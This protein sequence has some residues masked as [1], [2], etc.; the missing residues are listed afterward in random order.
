M[1]DPARD[2]GAKNK[3]EKTKP[4]FELS[5]LDA[6]KRKLGSGRF[7][8]GWAKSAGWWLQFGFSVRGI[9]VL[10]WKLAHQSKGKRPGFC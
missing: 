3:N 6:I 4:I 1:S 2:S 8:V 5:C 10:A 7:G 9:V